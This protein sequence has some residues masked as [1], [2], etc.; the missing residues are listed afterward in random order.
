[1]LPL[2][3]NFSS[4][5]IPALIFLRTSMPTLTATELELKV[6][7]PVFMM[8]DA[9]PADDKDD[10]KDEDEEDIDEEDMDDD[11]EDEEEGDEEKAD[12]AV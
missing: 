10:D 1:M 11:D 7:A 5:N 3:K 12:D 2:P 8:D 9:D 4:Y 6:L